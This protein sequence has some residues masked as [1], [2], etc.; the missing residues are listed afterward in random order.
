[1]AG[2]GGAGNLMCEDGI[3]NGNEAHIDCGD[4]AGECGDCSFP[5]T[6]YIEGNTGNMGTVTITWDATNL[7][8]YF[9]VVDSTAQNDSALHWEDDSVELYL[10]LNNGK[11]GAYQSDDHQ[12]TIARGATDIQG[13]YGDATIGSIVVVRT[14]DAA[15]YTLDVTIPWAALGL[16]S[17][18]VGQNIGFDFAVNND[19][20]GGTR[21]SQI[22][23]FGDTDN[24]QDTTNFGT[25]TI[26]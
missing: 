1:M 25:I 12:I 24:H 22:M 10:D 18:P 16:G 5:L 14:T 6:R 13:N 9:D 8:Y 4:A 2:A 26:R 7:Y 19:T 23:V 21:N 20:D 11:S 3:K 15:G 17:A